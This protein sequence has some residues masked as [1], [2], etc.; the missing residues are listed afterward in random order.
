VQ[1]QSLSIGEGVLTRG[2]QANLLKRMQE[3][4]SPRRGPIWMLQNVII[5][6]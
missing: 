4:L 6:V 3:R 2:S 1:L 5:Y